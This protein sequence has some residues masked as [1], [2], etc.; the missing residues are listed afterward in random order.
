[1]GL[2]KILLT[3]EDDE[4]DAALITGAESIWDD[5]TVV[6]VEAD[7]VRPADLPSPYDPERG[8]RIIQQREALEVRERDEIVSRVGNLLRAVESLLRLLK[9]KGMISDLD[10]RRM[11]QQ[12]DLE[13]GVADGAFHHGSPPVPSRCPKCEARIPSGKRTCQLCGSRVPVVP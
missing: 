1:M 4:L 11:E 9:D 13:D 2:L 7:A 3:G 6:L 8:A 5:D 12:I 10:L